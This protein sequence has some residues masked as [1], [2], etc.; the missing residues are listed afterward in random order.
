M[1]KCIILV[2][3]LVLCI[4]SFAHA[5]VTDPP[6]LTAAMFEGP[7]LLTSVGQS[8]DVNI[9]NTLLT[10]AGVPDVRLNA[11]VTKDD[12]GD[13]KTLV[14]AVGGSSKG[15]GAAG[16]DENQELDRVLAL[17]EAAQAAEIKILS[18]HIGGTA[19]RGTLSDKFIPDAIGAANAAIIK[20]DGDTDNLMRNLLVE[21]EIPG[22][23]VP[24]QIDV[25]DQLKL[26]FNIQ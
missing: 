9:V 19:R 16:I 1:K 11:T 22:A 15:L 21:K 18:L 17:I 7:V 26:V 23:F 24:G 6:A 4:A 20:A 3:T 5:E 2:L 14:L 8:A 13:A 25:V 12:L 10:K